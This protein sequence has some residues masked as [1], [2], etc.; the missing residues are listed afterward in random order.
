MPSPAATL[1]LLRPEPRGFS[2]FL[3]KRAKGSAFMPNMWVFPGGRVDAGDASVPAGSTRGGEQTI[4]R[5]GFDPDHGRAVLVAGV[6]ET[7]EE[8][9]LW[10]GT[11]AP[12]DAARDALN[13]R[14]VTFD[15]LLRD[16]S[17]VLDLGALH[18]WSRWVTP[19]GE[20]RRFDTTF[21]VA[22]APE[23]LGRHDSR[24]TV[25]SGWFT[26]A[27]V[28]SAGIG[29]MGLAPPTWW[30]LGELAAH[31]DVE[32]VL[33]AARTRDLSP[34]R[35]DL[36]LSDD[37]FAIVL[38]GHPRHAEPRRADLPTRIGLRDGAWVAG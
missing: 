1:L 8:A 14:T 17:S 11:G 27:E 7:F 4:A 22:V 6:R 30:T 23:G 28:L 12:P 32:Q 25:D 15:A 18:G 21:L 13:D 5:F 26:P 37:G 16:R 29:Q 19:A 31:G 35:P 34:V 9:G 24:E 33:S 2:V 38:P 10:L 36:D 3:V 20:P